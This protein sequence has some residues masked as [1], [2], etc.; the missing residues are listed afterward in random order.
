MAHLFNQSTDQGE[1]WAGASTL[2]A[3]SLLIAHQF[4]SH[5]RA[6]YLLLGGVSAILL[7]APAAV[8][9]P[10]IGVAP[11][12]YIYLPMAVGL[13]LAG[14]RWKGSVPRAWF[15]AI[16]LMSTIGSIRV[17]NRVGAFQSD[18]TLWATERALEPDNPYAAGGLARAWIGT[19]RHREAVDLWAKAA[20]QVRPGIRVFDKANERW[21]LAQAAFLKDAPDVAL[22]QVT[23]LL[24]EAKSSGSPAPTMA[25]CLVADSL[26]APG[27]HQEAELAS[28]RCKP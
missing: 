22:D 26:D 27:R 5:D 11:F 7:L 14:G 10:F 1:I 16:V 15:I 9:I 25:H 3:L 6:L 4:R 23:K 18:E 28:V 21:L 2:V 19:G 13:A 8:G 24:D 20:D 12:R 17:I